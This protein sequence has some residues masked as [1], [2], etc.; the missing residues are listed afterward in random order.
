MAQRR[1]S[2][3]RDSFY[4][5]FVIGGLFALVVFGPHLLPKTDGRVWKNIY[6]S[7][8]T[9]D[10]AYLPCVWV[11]TMLKN[12]TKPGDS[13]M[14]RPW[15]SG[16]LVVGGL[17][18]VAVAASFAPSLIPHFGLLEGILGL[19]LGILSAAAV[20]DGAF[21][22]ALQTLFGNGIDYARRFFPIVGVLLCV[23]CFGLSGWGLY[24]RAQAHDYMA[25]ADAVCFLTGVAGIVI[26]G[27]RRMPDAQPV[28]A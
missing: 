16:V 22:W 3:L 5:V 19:C 27:Q 15:L 24:Q 7:S 23:V 12:G 14:R 8:A 4:L 1:S 18:G 10:D 9:H 21:G 6:L 20:R 25:V 11:L 13:R 17:A 2:D 28:L 26:G